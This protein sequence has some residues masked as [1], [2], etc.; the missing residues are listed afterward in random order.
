MDLH[1]LPTPALVLDVAR[2]RRNVARMRERA[3]ALGV[4]L[5]P[6]VKTHKC[7]EI[8]RLQTEDPDRAVTVSTLAEAAAFAAHGFRDITY[9]VP[10]EPGK[11]GA[12][13]DL[14]AAGLG[15]RVITDD[16]GVAGA[17][18]EAA[19][20]RG[21]TIEVFVKVDCGYHRCG[22]DPAG[23]AALDVPR[24][25]ARAR[26][27]RLA[28]LLTHAGHAYHAATRDERL[29]IAREE[30]DVMVRFAARLRD[31]GVEVPVVSI[32]STPTLTVIDALDGVDEIRPGNYALFDAFQATLGT[33]AWDDCALTVLAAVVS[34]ECGRRQVVLDAGAI[35]LSKDQGALWL[36]PE[37]GYGR[38][39]D[40]EGRD[41]GLRVTSVSQEHGVVRAREEEA[42]SIDRLPVG[43]RV[44][45]LANHACL[46]A[47]Q[48][49][50]FHVLEG[51]RIVD[52][53]AIL[54]G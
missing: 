39:L 13:L 40:L 41:L 7:V 29:A 37:C 2:L 25:I 5:R 23:R 10:I 27:L 38:V 32:G 16:E 33:C 6:H 28:G 35:A 49:D 48:H 19:N 51:D 43:A 12:A 3:R 26:G 46:T 24:R 4:R 17:L 14:V 42:A 15:L 50:S 34:R 52:R 21:L 54:R 47:A 36:D 1:S 53:W 8:A 20:A 11:F 18:D 30:R 9:A 44:R 22:V 31:A 45:I